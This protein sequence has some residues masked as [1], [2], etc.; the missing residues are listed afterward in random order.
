MSFLSFSMRL[1]TLNFR[2][3]LSLPSPADLSSAV[4]FFTSLNAD[5]IC[6]QEVDRC[7]PRSS[8]N[9][10]TAEIARA[11]AF[12]GHF[13]PALSCFGH[14]FGLA[15]L[16]RFPF[17]L[18]RRH[19]LPFRGE[20]RIFSEVWL[21]LPFDTAPIRVINLHLGLQPAVRVQQ[22]RSLTRH[23]LR[24]PMRTLV[25]GDFNLTSSET[26]LKEFSTSAFLKEVRDPLYLPTFPAVGAVSRIDL[27]YHSSDFL[28]KS[29]F[30]SPRVIS[31]HLAFIADFT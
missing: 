19:L 2:S 4:E 30:V 28:V 24:R 11:L 25:C 5:V 22:V 10:Q 17:H 8:W 18:R 15:V 31:D 23:L 20:P 6:L 21:T 16:S 27:I 26:V 14:G 1:V 13:F 7:L 3:G 29:A 12:K 9:D